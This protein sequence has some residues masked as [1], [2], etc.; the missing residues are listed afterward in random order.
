LAGSSGK[1]KSPKN[2]VV[3]FELAS[4][5]RL[6]RFWQIGCVSCGWLSLA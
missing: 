4:F 5:R 2:F 3:R 6:R 1:R